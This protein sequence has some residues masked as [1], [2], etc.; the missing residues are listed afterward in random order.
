M[1]AV[2]CRYVCLVFLLVGS[3]TMSIQDIIGWIGYHARYYDVGLDTTS[4]MVLQ[5]LLGSIIISCMCLRLH[6]RIGVAF[7]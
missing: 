4:S 7:W 6:E 2:L 3:C 5:F 1:L